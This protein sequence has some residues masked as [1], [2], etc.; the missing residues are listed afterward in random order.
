MS[1]EKKAVKGIF[2]SVVEG[3][4]TQTMS[5]VIFFLLARLLS[6]EDF[7]LLAMANVFWAFMTVFL[8]QGFAQA[9][10]QCRK[11]EPEHL[12]TAFW[13]NLAI[14][15]VLASVSLA[16][17]G[18]VA[19][20]FG[21]PQLAPILQCFSAL[22]VI[23]ALS[24]V[25]K[26]LLERSFAFKAIAARS[27]LGLLSGG[28]VGITLALSGYGVWS[29]V[30]QR[31][32]HEA[33]GSLVL[34]R[35]SHW[36]P[37]LRFSKPHFNQLFSFG[38]S[39]L[40]L[41]F[42]GFFNK[43]GNDLLI[44]Y[45]LGPVS[46]GY[47]AIAYRV[48]ET[49]MQLLVKT[50]SQVALPTFSR[51]QAD[52][53]QFRKVF[54]AATQLTSLVA[55]PTFLGLAV[56]APE[57]IA[58]LFGDKWQA[59]VPIIQILTLSGIVQSVSAFKGHILMAMG[60]PSWRLW[61]SLLSVT[62]NIIGFIV[63]FQWGIAAVAIAYVIRRYIVFPV[64]QWAIYLLIHFSWS[65]YLRQFVT[66]AISAVAMAAAMFI[67]RGM[68]LR[69]DSALLTIVI[70]ALIGITVYIALVKLLSPQLFQMLLNLCHRFMHKLKPAAKQS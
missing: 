53:E 40:A 38:I 69:L 31:I 21:Q 25:Q 47:Y 66:P 22:F 52:L 36:R 13:T 39:L 56:L 62:L 24:N 68:M 48:L 58:L 4:G 67:A 17:A 2:W 60:K 44:G 23:T 49:L 43:R 27:L 14:G 42:I 5:L 3:W 12:D 54:Y 30:G 8:D 10:I 16:S 45:Y 57:V 55:F 34:W 9:L 63:A 1:I 50:T 7:G 35:A 61:Q 46:L 28:A 6:P 26:A 65:T 29:L 41:N 11:L 19:N 33:V 37:Q 51:L 32:T 20:G 15:V 70:C 59:S 64:G 18:V